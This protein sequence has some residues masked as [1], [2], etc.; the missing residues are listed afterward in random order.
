MSGEGKEG[1]GGGEGDEEGEDLG[2]AGGDDKIITE[3]LT[4]T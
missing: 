3:K 2:D 1:V 4:P